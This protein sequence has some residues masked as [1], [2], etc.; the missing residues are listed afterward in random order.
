MRSI[1]IVI[2]NRMGIGKRIKTRLM[3]ICVKKEIDI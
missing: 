2:E 3:F 1:L